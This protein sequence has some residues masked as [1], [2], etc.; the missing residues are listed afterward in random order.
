MG[1]LAKTQQRLR[2]SDKEFG[3]GVLD[4]QR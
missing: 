3:P 4:F 2:Y 1:S